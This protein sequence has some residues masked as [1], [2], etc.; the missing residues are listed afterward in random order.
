MDQV[1]RQGFRQ[2]ESTLDSL[3]GAWAAE[4]RLGVSD[5]ETVRRNLMLTAQ[6]AIT[7]LTYAWWR[8]VLEPRALAASKRASDSVLRLCFRPAA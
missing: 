1:D 6:G 2:T 4:R 5:S 8:G 3:L 7:E